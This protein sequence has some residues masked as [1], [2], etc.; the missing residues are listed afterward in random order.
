[1]SFFKTYK[2]S[3]KNKKTLNIV[4]TGGSKGIGL[5]MTKKFLALNHNVLICA[6]NQKGITSAIESINSKNLDGMVCDVTKPDDVKN[7]I[8]FCEDKFKTIDVW[9]NNAGMAQGS[10]KLQDIPDDVIESCIDVNMK[11]SM[12]CCK[13]L[14]PVLEKQEKGGHIF[15]FEGAGSDGRDFPL[16]S[17]Y[18]ASKYGLSYFTK[19]LATQMKDTNVGIHIIQ[20]GM[21]VT[22][23]LVGK[24]DDMTLK[25]K[26]ILNIMA[27]EADVV[28]DFI[29]PNVVSVE[30]NNQAFR[31]LT[32]F[33][34]MGRFITS[35]SRKNRFFNEETGE[36]TVEY[37]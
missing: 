30:G 10:S 28:A 1:M 31:F 27:E 12:Y 9:I 32:F 26:K 24:K 11:G 14:L 35:S 36:L 23:L 25:S 18:G 2:N 6:R 34:I 22:D 16:L 19:Q 5:A 21:V 7:F 15:M 37:N 33:G 13:Y 8:K 17:V 3:L 29:V 20:P 4:I